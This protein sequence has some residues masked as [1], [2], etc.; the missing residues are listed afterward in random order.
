MNE[1]NEKIPQS[2]QLPEEGEH[3]GLEDITAPK[4]K[5]ETRFQ[6]FLRQ[7]LRWLGGLL[8]VFGLGVLASVFLLYQPTR[9]ELTNLTGQLGQANQQISQLQNEINGLK[10]LEAK[11]K[12]L[13][14]QLDQ[15]NL[16]IV[17]L[18]GLSDVNAARLAL[19]NDDQAGA[20]LHLTN[21]PKTLTD[22][23][24]L[25]G[26]NQSEKVKSMQDR[27]QLAVSEISS[28]KFAAKSDLSVLAED[29]VQLE[30]TF[31]A[32]P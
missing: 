10:P 3:E 6:R 7:A 27:L 11:N 23:E 22:L 25:V 13:Q 32:T 15:A 21:T 20:K 16:H 1:S 31:F 9:Q 30:N 17:I 12:D 2:E 24:S 8:I 28:N 4:A 29:L 26:N 18:S 14:N 5:P 19:A